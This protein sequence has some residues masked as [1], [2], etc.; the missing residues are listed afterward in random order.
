MHKPTGYFG[1]HYRFPTHHCS[2]TKRHA[3]YFCSYRTRTDGYGIF[4]FRNCTT[5]N[6]NTIQVYGR[7]AV[8]N[9]NW[10][11]SCKS[12]PVRSTC[13]RT[14]TDRNR[15]V[16]VAKRTTT[17]RHSAYSFC[18]IIQEIRAIRIS[19]IICIY[20]VITGCSLFQLCHVDGIRI[21]STCR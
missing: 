9:S 16:A 17:H 10:I 21:R 7:C 11:M 3:I 13:C 18:P 6:S 8:T 4:F 5:A 1:G 19:R 2:R 12:F 15:M 14:I 20:A